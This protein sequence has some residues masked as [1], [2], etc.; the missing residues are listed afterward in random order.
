MSAQELNT[1]FVEEVEKHRVLYDFECPGYSRKDV[2]DKAW[3]EVAAK[4][5]LPAAECK[6]KWRN[7]RTVFI[8]KMKNSLT[9]DESS[10]KKRAPYY[11]TEA[12]QFCVPFILPRMFSRSQQPPHVNYTPTDSSHCTETNDG[13]PSFEQQVFS[14]TEN[15]D[16]TSTPHL[17]SLLLSP[18]VEHEYENEE[19][20][21]ADQPEVKRARIESTSV[22]ETTV[23]QDVDKM[24]AL[25][26]YLLS[27]LPELREFNDSQVKKFKRRVFDIIDEISNNN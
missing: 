21:V 20:C 27:L 22:H 23:S 15:N 13:D 9:D 26:M 17:A 12:M 25:R 4:V 11:L 19:Q 24:E 7:L 18:K 10:R 3:Q 8:R 2:T 1:A 14:S 5:N 16:Q 6:E